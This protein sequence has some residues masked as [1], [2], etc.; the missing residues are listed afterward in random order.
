[1][2]KLLGLPPIAAEG[3]ESVD[4][5]IIYVHWLMI[6]LF[7]GWIT[8]FGLTLF[9]FRSSRN[10]R[11]DYQGVK[12]HAS[13]YIEVAVAGVEVLLL[14]FVALPLWRTHAKDFPKK[15]DSTVIY[16]VAQ[17]FAWNFRY[18]DKDG[19]IGRQDMKFVTSDNLFG[20]DP[21]DT[22]H[23]NAVQ[24]LNEVH[25]PLGKPVIAYMSSKDVIHDFR[26][27]AMRVAQDTIPGMR[28]PVHFTPTKEGRYQINC[29]QLC[30]NGH[31]SMAQGFLVVES[32]EEF[33]KWMA[34]KAGAATSF[35]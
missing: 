20:I 7:V 18:A 15:T 10:P 4:Q 31:A 6:A 13:S 25:V 22:S 3:G 16:V 34:S 8:Y 9:R 1:M 23:K 24:T 35:E 32:P 19:E 30:G 14:V 33:K 28:I 29:A 26:I 27:I 21:A 12:N 11:G 2:E 5:L 17:Q